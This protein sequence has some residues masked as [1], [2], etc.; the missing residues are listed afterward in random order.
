MTI[1]NL[2]TMFEA[3]S[4]AI[5]GASARTSSV[6]YTV[7]ANQLAAGADPVY[8]VNPK[9]SE[10]D[11][12]RC[13]ASI[14]ELPAA[15]DLAVLTTPPETVP[16]LI[17]ELGAAGTRAA[18]VV[19]A[20]IRGELRQRML[21]AARPTCLRILGPN[22]IGLI[23]P[24]FGINASFAHVTPN[25]GD[26]AFLSQSGAI[27]TSVLD[28]AHGRDIGF[29]HVASMGD[30]ADVDFGDML[31]YLA[32]DIS[33][34]AIL[35]YVESITAAPKFVSAARSAARAK[36]VIVVKAGRHEAGARAAA[37]HTGALA[38]SD[39]VYDAVFRRT[40]LLRVY[41]LDE[42]FAAAEVL[43]RLGRLGGE[44]LTIV[45]NGGGA[46][47]LA[48]DRLADHSGQLTTL[49]QQTIA[50]L[51]EVLPETWSKSNPV[52][53]IGDAGPMRYASTLNVL[54]DDKESDALLVINCPV[55][56]ASSTAAAEAVIETLDD[57][58]RP[59]SRR[60][61]VLVNWLGESSARDARRLFAMN[62]IPAFD[63][64]SDAINGF[65]Q[66][67]RYTRGQKE[68]LR[69]PAM[70]PESRT[71]EGEKAEAVIGDVLAEGRD[72]LTEV[73]AKQVLADYDIPVL[74][75]LIAATPAEAA[76][77]A[78]RL[79]ADHDACVVK[80]LSKEITHKSDVGGVALNLKS[81]KATEAAAEAMLQ[82]VARDVP[83]AGVEGFTVQ[84]MVQK[85]GGIELLAGMTVD[86][87][88]G[89]VLMFGQGGTAVEVLADTAMALPPL[90]LAR[91]EDTMQA[92]RVYRLLRGYRDQ[93][94]ADLSAIALTLVKLGKLVSEHEAVRELDINP[95]IA[96]HAGVIA[97]DAR[98][99]VA[100]PA[101]SPRPPM[102]VRPYPIAWERHMHF[103]GIG[104]IIVRPIRPDDEHLYDGL[105]KRM[106]SNDI[107]L[108]LFA[109]K[110][111]LSHKFLARLTQID[112]AR[113]IAF[114][115]VSLDPKELLGV[116]R[117][118]ADPDHRGA[119]YAVLVRS[120]LKGLGLGWLLMCHLI[121]YARSEGLKQLHGTVLRENTTMQR[122]CTDLGFSVE[123]DPDDA[124]VVRV[125]LPLD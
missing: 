26:L 87:T 61:P 46:G 53:I 85:P 62:G 41:D 93:P 95:L 1:R 55:A 44:S 56:L 52:D 67:V 45:T 23:V 119:E 13:Y 9:Y 121:D 51:N 33:S 113:E 114:V 48:A 3:R 103:N 78:E 8:L 97:L 58:D 42:L 72:I 66:L 86:P 22:C 49:S 73:E 4:V 83:D 28:W 43:S 96:D 110:K 89:P 24:A 15:P 12:V 124:G 30:K 84:P 75:S 104:E 94:P 17:A 70:L 120:D 108:R 7:A 91:A 63:T 19:T 38:G 109:P 88:F 122:M 118:T 47:V 57:H 31:D 79:L 77:I 100:D 32:G 92:T 123:P 16:G 76:E 74:E 107:R 59:Y 68:L 80:I 69:T 14:A 27:I 11:G 82:R 117:Y 6:G 112:Y 54:L 111:Q 21:D 37:S 10:I 36:P 60:T 102:A 90:D 29:S 105:M 125:T 106:D 18:V 116:V 101:T 20:G 64:P 99:R 35:L 71:G 34:R 98:L 81:A 5:I 40:G 115:A 39:E 50:Q 65:M 2:D 25:A